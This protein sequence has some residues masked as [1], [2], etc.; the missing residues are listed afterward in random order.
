MFSSNQILD[1]SC[2]QQD[3]GEIIKFAIGLYG[4]DLFTRNDGRLKV[5]YSEPVPGVYA[6]GRGSFPGFS[7]N[8]GLAHP[9]KRGWTDYPFDYDPEIIAGIINQWVKKQSAP[10]HTGTD[11]SEHLGIRVRCLGSI[12]K[13]LP[14][15][16]ELP[17][18]DC[19]SCILLFTPIHLAYDK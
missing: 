15:R 7:N 9:A 13:E 12:G 5:A 6:I 3:L 4:E 11:G 8:P 10:K 1:V 16:Y 14:P 2:E 18:W 17:D 19:F